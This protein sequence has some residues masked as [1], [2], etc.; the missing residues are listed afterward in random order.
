MAV[1]GADRKGVLG[2]LRAQMAAIE[3]SGTKA[4][5]V[6][7]LGVPAL[8]ACLPGGGLP[9][10][11]WHEIVGDGLE[12]EDPAAAAG[13][14][15][16]LAAALAAD[17]GETVWVFRRADL[18]APG[19][20]ALG[21]DPARLL[22][23]AVRRDEE[24][25][26]AMEDALRATGVAA[27]LGEAEALDLTAGRRLQLACEQTGATGL[28]LKRRRALRSG[29]SM[30]KDQG[31]GSGATTRWRVSPAP[32][33]P[34]QPGFAGLGPP[35]WRVELVRCRGGRTGSWVLEAAD[36]PHPLRLV[37]ELADHDL[38]APPSRRR[39]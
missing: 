16:R 39:A 10:G 31:E 20:A 1:G 6:L 29:G 38:Q 26:A 3:T 34:E 35:C 21:L 37:A 5:R 12:A 18:Y 23:V 19:L 30:S 22:F 17:G 9:R 13:F 4:G 25:L 8:D 14:A 24:A 36:G 2:A 33:R 32:S 11:R 28:V 27:V 15:A 7:P